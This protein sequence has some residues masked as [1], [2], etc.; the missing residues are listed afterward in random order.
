MQFAYE[1]VLY[2]TFNHPFDSNEYDHNADLEEIFRTTYMPDTPTSY[3][4]SLAGGGSLKDDSYVTKM[5]GDMNLEASVS[6]KTVG[7]PITT[8][9][10]NNTGVINKNK[11]SIFGSILNGTPVSDAIDAISKGVYKTTKSVVEGFGAGLS[12]MGNS[13]KSSK[14]QN[15]ITKGSTKFK[16]KVETD[17]ANAKVGMKNDA[18]QMERDLAQMQK[19]QIA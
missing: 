6:G 3:D 17:V 7:P 18:K 1:T 15:W 2:E 8:I 14:K 11:G 13:N 9:K 4:A 12:T 10:G 19:N 16:S 5:T